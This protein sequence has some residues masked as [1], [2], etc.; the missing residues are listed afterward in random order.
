MI[1]RWL[2]AVS[3]A[4]LST[5]CQAAPSEREFSEDM[6]ARL[7]VSEPQAELR[8][9]ADE[10]LVIQQVEDGKWDKA[11][12]NLH[13]VYQ[14]CLSA[15]PADCEASKREFAGKIGIKPPPPKPET[16]RLIV[17]GNDYV[18]YVR[19]MFGPSGKLLE[20]RQ[21]GDDLY[22]ILAF[23]APDTIA[24][25]TTDMLKDLNLTL[26]AAWFLAM[27]QTKAVLP[28]LPDG[29][30]LSRVAM[31]YQDK[32]YLGSLLADPEGWRRVASDAGPNMFVTV[33]SDQFVFVGMMPDGPEL[34]SFKQSVAEDC[35]Q[36]QRC[37]SEHVYRFRDGR[38]TIA[39]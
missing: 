19:E 36:Q 13:R 8:I 26:D 34:D 15:I 29:K 2:I 23:D 14:Y 3:V 22:A 9:K 16:L 4:G 37:T 5:A 1:R 24:V 10:P 11:F 6:L 35:L 7:R 39:K 21:I 32:E 30:K 20:P 18:A 25:A 33:V 38:W 31:A 27:R 12:I 17:R 28:P